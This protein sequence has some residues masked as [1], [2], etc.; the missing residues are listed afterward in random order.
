MASVNAQR[1]PDPAGT[2]PLL[3]RTKE[4]PSRGS[5]LT[6]DAIV[7]AAVAIAD[8]D[9]L[10]AVTMRSVA[11]RLGVG[12]MSLYTHVPGKGEL[13]AL[14]LDHVFADALDGIAT[15]G[16]WRDRLVAVARLDRDRYLGH[17]WLLE[18]PVARPA[19]GPNITAKYERDLAAL[20]GTGLTAAELNAAVMTLTSFVYGAAR[21]QSR[22]RADERSGRTEAEFWQAHEPYL[23]LVLDPERFPNARKVAEEVGRDS[24]S[25][26]D[27]DFSFEFGLERFL[28]GIQDLVDRRGNT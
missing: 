23:H 16:T 11:E 2:L 25:E 1:W 14:M 17:P 18:L 21:F 19:F 28:V 24:G 9:G 22:A 27:H 13:H 7:G 10:D 5:G 15:Q 26:A 4:R 20:E 3:W 6:I 12:A 8:A